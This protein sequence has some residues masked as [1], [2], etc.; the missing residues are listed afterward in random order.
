[1]DLTPTIG[2]RSL[3]ITLQLHPISF[4]LDRNSR[5]DSRPDWQAVGSTQFQ[6]HPIWRRKNQLSQQ[7][8]SRVIW[9]NELEIN[10]TSTLSETTDSNNNKLAKLSSGFVSGGA[11]GKRMDDFCR[12]IKQEMQKE[13]SMLL[14]SRDIVIELIQNSLIA[15]P[16]LF[17][18]GPMQRKLSVLWISHFFKQKRFEIKDTKGWKFL[19]CV[20]G[21]AIK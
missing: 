16:I 2:I 21:S 18:C 15:E 8:Q 5:P 6:L 9:F 20:T 1:M 13:I 7:H 19:K 4:L 14:S 3:R 17:L 11:E 12:Y 10:S